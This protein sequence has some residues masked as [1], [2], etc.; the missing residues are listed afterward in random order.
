MDRKDSDKNTRKL[1]RWGKSS[2]GIT[3]PRDILNDLGWEEKQK[4]IAKKRGKTIIIEDW[5]K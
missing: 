4:V 3:L 5:G 2:L 1:L